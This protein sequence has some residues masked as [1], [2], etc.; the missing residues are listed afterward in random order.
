MAP[1]ARGQ[2]RGPGTD[3]GEEMRRNEKKQQELK[4]N[5][6]TR[7]TS[8]LVYEFLSKFIYIAGISYRKLGSSHIKFH[9]TAYQH[10]P[11]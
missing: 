5:V 10:T 11:F 9:L 1:G 6:K 7:Q 4:V 2:G 3:D 8:V